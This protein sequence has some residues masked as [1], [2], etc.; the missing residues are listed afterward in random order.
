MNENQRTGYVK[1]VDAKTKAW[2]KHTNDVCKTWD[3]EENYC[4]G[5]G[6]DAALK[7]DDELFKLI[8]TKALLAYKE[9]E[10]SVLMN[11]FIQIS[12]LCRERLRG[13]K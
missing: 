6:F 12:D 7:E 3:C 10:L 8:N 2:K 1:I 13:L 5:Y 4:F 11:V 9:E